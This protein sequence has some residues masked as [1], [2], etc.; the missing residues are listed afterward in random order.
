MATLIIEHSD[1]TGA[2]RL[3]DTLRAHG[4]NLDIR[5]MHRGDDLPPDLDQVDAIVVCGGAYSPDDKTDWFEPLA[6]LLRQAHELDLPLVGICFGNQFLAQALGGEVGRLESGV[7]LGWHEV[8]LNS[9][10]R[11]DPLHAGLAWTSL[12]PCWNRWAVTTL[13]PG[14]RTLA[15]TDACPNTTWA[16][17]L[18]TYGF[19][20]HPEIYLDTFDKWAAD[21]PQGLEEVGLTLEELRTQTDA[22]FPAFERLSNRLFGAIALL[23][24]P[25]DRR[26]AGATKDLHH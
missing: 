1:I 21:E 9:A 23:L 14:A 13:P 17:G 8:R 26:Y 10:G 22:N 25:V 3:G 5:R 19:Q 7:Q 4:H 6:K 15:S 12:Q 20:Y 2:D 24:M 11:E 16:L 18:R